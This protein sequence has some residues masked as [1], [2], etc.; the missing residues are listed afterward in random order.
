MDL[1]ILQ[2][3]LS[4]FQR[5]VELDLLTVSIGTQAAAVAVSFIVAL[6]LANPTRR[7]FLR[8][9]ERL[10]DRWRDAVARPVHELTLF[11]NWLILQIGILIFVKSMGWPFKLL[12][13]TV[14]LLTAWVIIRI[15]SQII[16]EPSWASLFAATAWTIAALHIVDLLPETINLLEA[17]TLNIG[18]VKISAL[19]VIEGVLTLIV[20]LW[21]ATLS[22][23]LVVQKIQ[24][25]PSLTPSVQVLIS[26]VIKIV[27]VII[28]ILVATNAAGIDLTA[29][30]VFSGAVGVG[31]GFGLQKVFA[32]FISGIIL[33]LDRSVKP[34]DTIVVAGQYGR[35]NELGARYASV[36]TRDGIEHLVPN[37][38][39]INT[40]VENWSHSDETIRL[41]IDVGVHY[42]SDLHLAME[43]ML[44]AAVNTDRILKYPKPVCLLTGF[45]DSAV[46]L[47]VRFWINDPM[48]GRANI[49]SAML[50]GIWERFTENGIKIPYPQ[51][52][53]HLITSDFFPER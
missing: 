13:V 40:R 48:N 7:T 21:F 32:N 23:R 26:K 14:S 1:L 38:E 28:A 35:V 46:N 2:K 18:S 49:T 30:A 9:F 20:L 17:A 47:Q 8:F 34:G 39:F 10:P 52:D 4:S 42:H 12:D 15:A 50:M 16:R 51:R 33:L 19:K 25:L 43:L 41:K 29:L 53:L 11:I 45:G 3:W 22:S 27:F 5:W 31:I 36:I 6:T 44:D 37:E 24:S